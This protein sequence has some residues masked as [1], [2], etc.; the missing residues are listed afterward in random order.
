MKD[1]ALEDVRCPFNYW[2]ELEKARRL[3]N[4]KVRECVF[5]ERSLG[6]RELATRFNVSTGTLSAIV[7]R[8][9]KWQPIVRR[10]RVKEDA[11]DDLQCPFNYKKE[12]KIARVALDKKLIA[13]V[14]KYRRLSYRDLAEKFKLSVG[15]LFVI[16]R[17][18]KEKLKPGRWPMNW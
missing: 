17:G 3:L 18:H 2:G 13:S 6:Y 11:F 16:A 10:A 12:L 8:K 4:K 14:S 15:T 5:R 7:N 1:D 9:Q